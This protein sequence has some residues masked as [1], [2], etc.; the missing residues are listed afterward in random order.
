M[1]DI[2]RRRKLLSRISSVAYFVTKSFKGN[3][4]ANI[5]AILQFANIPKGGSLEFAVGCY[6]ME[7]GT[8]KV[9][10]IQSTIVTLSS[11][12][13]SYTTSAP[14][15]QQGS[16]SGQ[17]GS[18]SGQAGAAS[19]ANGSGTA[20]ND[21]SAAAYHTGGMGAPAVAGLIAAACALVA[22]AAGLV[23]YRRRNRSRLM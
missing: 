13:K 4:T 1:S 10:W 9:S 16:T 14:S 12:G 8:G 21:A 11:D 18:T 5:G 3:S 19:G 23:W 22:A 17:Q 15:G 7:G 6:S 2:Q 20:A